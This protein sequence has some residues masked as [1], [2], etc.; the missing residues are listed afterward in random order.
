MQEACDATD[1]L[2]DYISPLESSTIG[3]QTPD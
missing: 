2:A 1:L 3:A